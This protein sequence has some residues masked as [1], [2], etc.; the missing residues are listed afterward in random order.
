LQKNEIPKGSRIVM[1]SPPNKGTE[2]ADSL[3]TKFLYKLLTGKIG[4][5]L[6]TDSELIMELQNIKYDVGI[7]TGIKSLNRISSKMIPGEDDGRVS[8]Q[9]AKLDEMKDFLIVNETH[10]SIKFDKY[11][12]DQVLFFIKSGYFDRK[13]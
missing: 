5:E 1:L 8:T 7:I 10:L 4:E 6:C 9:S 2:I 13:D 11:V 12:A 3:K